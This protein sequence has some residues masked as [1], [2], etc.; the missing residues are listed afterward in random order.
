MRFTR[1]PVR[2]QHRGGGVVPLDADLV[3]V[4]RFDRIEVLESEVV[5]E[6]ELDR[7]S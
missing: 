3:H 6:E 4:G 5:D 1:V 2:G 7:Q